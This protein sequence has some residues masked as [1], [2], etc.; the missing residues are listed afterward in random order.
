MLVMYFTNL[1]LDGF[2]VATGRVAM[3]ALRHFLPTL[4]GA[5]ASMPRSSRALLGW[6][7]LVPPQMRLPITRPA[8]LGIVGWLVANHQFGIALFTRIMFDT[9]LRP[10]EAYHLTAGAVVRPR[11]HASEGY[12]HFALIVNDAVTNRAGK[13]G[14]TDESVIVD[15]ETLWP[16][17]QALIEGKQPHES[18]DNSLYALRHGGAS[19]DLLSMRRTRKEVK[20]RGRWRTD[21]SLNRYAKRAR[22]QQLIAELGQLVID[23][24]HIVDN[25]LA[26]LIV[27]TRRLGRF[28]M[29]L[30][31]VPVAAL[32]AAT[33]V[34]PTLTTGWTFA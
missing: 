2:D 8:M 12:R 18:P 34:T 10:S 9:Y 22:M 1:L 6:R 28:P 23:F 3:A 26:K 7:K 17:L 25:H 33:A 31:A 27:D 19:D 5:K 32:R 21:Q 29:A 4:A 13:T 16:L 14:E 15:N 20:D 30:P 24:A 11:P